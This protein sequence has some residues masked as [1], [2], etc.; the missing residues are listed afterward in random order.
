MWKRS[1][2]DCTTQGEI[3]L[4]R[5]VGE[6]KGYLRNTAHNTTIAHQDTLSVRFMHVSLIY[7]DSHA[8][9]SYIYKIHACVLLCNCCAKIIIRGVISPV[10]RIH[11]QQ[12]CPLLFVQRITE[13]LE[14]FP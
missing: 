12:P 1:L 7:I 11:G 3:S 10:Q 8:C 4:G 9:E 14:L 5:G 13:N 6:G 2:R